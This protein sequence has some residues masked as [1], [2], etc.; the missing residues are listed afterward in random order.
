IGMIGVRNTSAD[1][2]EIRRLRVHNDFRRRG[3]GSR[4]MEQAISFCKHHGYL[5]VVL[6]V[7]VERGPAI[8][9]FEK[10]GFAVGRTRDQDGLKMLDF[11]M[12]IYN[13]PHA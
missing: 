5:K 11:Y 7:R 4:L 6:D 8:S 9:L 13:D 1:V 2:A 3:I 12:N 10:F